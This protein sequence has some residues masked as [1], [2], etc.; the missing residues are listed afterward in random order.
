[1]DSVNEPC[2]IFRGRAI[3][4]VASK[5]MMTEV[6]SFMMLSMV[7]IADLESRKDGVLSGS[8]GSSLEVG[9]KK[10]ATCRHLC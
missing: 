3:A 4:A 9:K 8:F 5:D 1:M 2:P 7:L 6:V 10:C